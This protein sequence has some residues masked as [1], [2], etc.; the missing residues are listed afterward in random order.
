MSAPKQ[1]A[2]RNL[3]LQ[4]LAPDDFDMLAPF[5]ECR[6][7]ARRQQLIEPGEPIA[8]VWFPEHGLGSLVAATPEGHSAEVGIVGRDGL[9]GVPLL[10]G[11]DRTMQRLLVQSEGVGWRIPAAPF[12]AALHQSRPLHWSLLRYV[13][14]LTTQA[15][16]TALSNAVHTVEERLARWLLMAH[17]RSDGDELA[18][19]HEFLALMLAVRRPTVTTSLHVLE[20]MGLI[21]SLRGLVVFR[22]RAGL[23]A[24]AADAYGIPEAEYGALIGPLRRTGEP[25]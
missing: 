21:R 24:L 16:H 14:A 1:H 19:T 12:L 7:L 9:S 11:S 15:G 23:E 17:D 25:A 4:S 2:V 20:G 6:P 5:L 3:L 22:D 18:L 8:H 10:L 13:Q